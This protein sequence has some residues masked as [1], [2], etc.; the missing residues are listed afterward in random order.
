MISHSHSTERKSSG[1]D[2]AI[3]AD[4]FRKAVQKP[5]FAYRTIESGGTSEAQ[6]QT[7]HWLLSRE[8]VEEGGDIRSVER[9]G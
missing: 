8:L 7:E 2:E 5:D 6:E 9:E 3:T 1:A 4:A